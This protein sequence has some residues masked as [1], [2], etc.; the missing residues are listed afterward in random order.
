MV[1]KA[2]NGDKVAINLKGNLA[3]GT[4]FDTTENDI[5]FVFIIGEPDVIKGLQ[6]G[7]IGMAEG[8]SREFV[9]KPE[10]GFGER[11][12]DLIFD[13]PL[14]DIETNE[15]VTIGKRYEVTVPGSGV[16][17]GTVIAKIKTVS[18]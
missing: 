11:I 5:P 18:P 6:E 1:K 15:T 14:I 17:E 3:D 7:V 13:V 4:V 2:K 12:D 10:D 8:D 16:M 9:V